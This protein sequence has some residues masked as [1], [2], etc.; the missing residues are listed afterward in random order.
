[1]QLESAFVQ[2]LQKVY[3]LFY[4]ESARLT[5]PT[6]VFLLQRIGPSP[7]QADFSLKKAPAQT[8]S[9]FYKTSHTHRR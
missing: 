2:L 8:S 5:E 7:V 9:V 1:M 3:T 4:L 6:S